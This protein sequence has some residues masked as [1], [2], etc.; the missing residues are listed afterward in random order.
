VPEARGDRRGGAYGRFASVTTWSGGTLGLDLG[1]LRGVVVV[2]PLSA[3]HLHDLDGR[4]RRLRRE[5]LD[6]VAEYELRG[7]GHLLVERLRWTFDGVAERDQYVLATDAARALVLLGLAARFQQRGNQLLLG[8]MVAAYGSSRGCSGPPWSPTC[9]RWS[10]PGWSGSARPPP[11]CAW[12]RPRSWWRPAARSRC[13]TG[14]DPRRHGPL[15]PGGGPRAT[16]TE[17]R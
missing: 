15:R 2:E 7:D 4:C 8:V 9:P 17:G 10:A 3:R 13:P 1:D 11:P 6:L 16:G 12:T 14:A 5:G